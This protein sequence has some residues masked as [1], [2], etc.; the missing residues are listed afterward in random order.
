LEQDGERIMHEIEW[1]DGQVDVH[2][3]GSAQTTGGVTNEPLT[4]D[5]VG[6]AERPSPDVAGVARGVRI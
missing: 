4:S 5:F 2:F 1:L 6:S 3:A